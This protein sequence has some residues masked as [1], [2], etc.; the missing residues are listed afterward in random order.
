MSSS[1]SDHGSYRQQL[2]PVPFGASRRTVS[3]RLASATRSIAAGRSLDEV[4]LE[5]VDAFG[6]API[7]GHA[8]MLRFDDLAGTAAGAAAGHGVGHGGGHGDDLGDAGPSDGVSWVGEWPERAHSVWTRPVIAPDGRVAALLVVRADGRA[9]PSDE[10]QQLLAEAV[11][12]AALA[13]GLHDYHETLR[14]AAYVDPLTGVGNR[15]RLQHYVSEFAADAQH[16]AGVLYLDLDDFK[17]INDRFGHAV[18]DVVL[19]QAAARLSLGIRA[20]DEVIRVGGDEFIVICREPAHPSDLLEIA[21]DL[22]R[23]LYQPYIVNGQ[24]ADS[25]AEVFDHDSSDR[26]RSGGEVIEVPGT[27]A[28][29]GAAHADSI[30]AGPDRLGRLITLADR[31]MYAAKRRRRPAAN[32]EDAS[33]DARSPFSSSADRDADRHSDPRSGRWGDRH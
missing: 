5:V 9:R 19:E 14:R 27:G 17:S 20:D 10:E 6:A 32:A 30:S 21:N 13:F 28:S 4:L 2:D 18:G 23:R 29:V 7:H 22:I 1:P 24:A 12:V 26:N 15:A 16:I 31:S 25:G 3:G 33:P 11:S 8:S